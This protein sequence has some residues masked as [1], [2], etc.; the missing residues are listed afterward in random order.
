MNKMREASD[1]SFAHRRSPQFSHKYIQPQR[2][3]YSRHHPLL[4]SARKDTT[5]SFFLYEVLRSPVRDRGAAPEAAAMSALVRVQSR[6]FS[7]LCRRRITTSDECPPIDP[8]ATETTGE[9]VRL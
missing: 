8:G 5:E 9:D 3:I 7:A 4:S 1:S 6:F 2:K